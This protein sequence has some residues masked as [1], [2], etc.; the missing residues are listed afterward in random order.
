[1][2]TGPAEPLEQMFCRSVSDCHL[3][4]PRAKGAGPDSVN[5][6]HRCD[7][8]VQ[9][10]ERPVKLVLEDTKCAPLLELGLLGAGNQR[11]T[12]LSHVSKA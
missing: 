6:A 3:C 1:M 9:G 4:V 2:E 10:E 8:R 12:A 7:K 11:R 5:G